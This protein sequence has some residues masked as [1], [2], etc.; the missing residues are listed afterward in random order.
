[1]LKGW[2]CEWLTSC[3]TW[4]CTIAHSLKPVLWS[5]GPCFR[6]VH[7][8]IVKGFLTSLPWKSYFLLGVTHPWPSVTTNND[9]RNNQGQPRLL[10][11]RTHLQSFLTAF[12]VSYGRPLT[13]TSGADGVRHSQ[14]QSAFVQRPSYHILRVKSHSG[15]WHLCFRSWLLHVWIGLLIDA[16]LQK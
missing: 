12:A 16:I 11:G 8:T 5:H 6:P 1:M 3:P 15:H 9:D 13:M 4:N 14:G 7:S 10:P 2:N